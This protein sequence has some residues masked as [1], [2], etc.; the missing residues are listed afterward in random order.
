MTS[1]EALRAIRSLASNGQILL[2]GHARERMAERSVRYADIRHA[3]ANASSA[4]PSEPGRWA[5]SGPDM[6]NDTLTVVVI[7]TGSLLVVTVY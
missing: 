6:S 7:I 4:E 3:L 1:A 5:A 2:G